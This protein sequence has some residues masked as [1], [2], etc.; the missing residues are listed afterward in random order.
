MVSHPT[1]EADGFARTL[2]EHGSGIFALN[3]SKILRF[4]DTLHI[5]HISYGLGKG[6]DIDA[7]NQV[8]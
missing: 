5:K 4:F 7:C 1:L 2:L 6:S 8:L 3:I